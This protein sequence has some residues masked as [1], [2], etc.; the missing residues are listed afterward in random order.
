MEWVPGLSGQGGD[1][2]HGLTLHSFSF[3]WEGTI[4]SFES[5]DALTSVVGDLK[6]TG[7]TVCTCGLMVFVIFQQI[8]CLDKYQ[9]LCVRISC[10]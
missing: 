1:R 3:C 5:Q 7:F 8:S 9:F 6:Q 10:N 2:S 4:L